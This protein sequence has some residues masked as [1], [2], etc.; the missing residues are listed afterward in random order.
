MK[1]LLFFFLSFTS[2]LA[3][4]AFISTVE[5]KERLHDPKLLLLDVAPR[6]AYTTSH[7]THAVHVDINAF[8]TMQNA[9]KSLKREEDIGEYLRDL[10]LNDDSQVV[11]YGR[12]TSQDQL[13]SSYLAFILLS[14]G[15][16]NVS[17]LD[18]AYMAWVFEN[19]LF[20]STEVF[21]KDE[22][23]F[24]PKRNDAFFISADSLQE[25]LENLILLDSRHSSEYF[26][27]ALSTGVAQIGHIPSAQSS[28]YQDKFLSDF[29]LR[30]QEELDLL[31]HEGHKLHKNESIVVYG[32]DARE[33]S[34]NWYLLYKYLGYENVKLYE[35][36]MQE[37][38][39]NPELPLK[40][41]LWECKK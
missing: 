22:G 32:T 13:N 10:G 39:N 1:Y 2:L 9:L 30:P 6:S 29:T 7:I 28:F 36:S 17:L 8:V 11:I 15:F 34:M 12:S 25:N 33:A 38:G 19:E 14:H 21:S 20:V 18:G 37:W 41:F 40:K 26:G 5:L 16:S 31:F 23:N 3:S 35:G 27:T 4:D 24:N